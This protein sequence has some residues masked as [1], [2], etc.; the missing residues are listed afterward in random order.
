MSARVD[1]P[2]ARGLCS[3]A[4]HMKK[5]AVVPTYNERENIEQLAR[6]VLAVDTETDVLVVDDNSPDGTGA[7][8]DALAS[9]EPRV[10][11]LHR[12][13]KAGIG[14]AYKAGFTRALDLGADLV[15]QMDADFSHPPQTLPEFYRL[16]HEYDLALGSRY[17][18]GIT[19]INW[20]MGRLMLS[21]FGN[22]Y[23]QKVLGGLPIKDTTGGYKCWRR[24]VLEAIG[25]ADVRSNGYAFQ[26]EMNYRAWRLGFR[27]KE[28]PIVFVDRRVGSSKMHLSIAVEALTIV[29]RLRLQSL[30]GRLGPRSAPVAARPQST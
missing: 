7:I 16:M 11:V 1:S 9:T 27:I 3:P 15:V 25:L 10:H 23:A 14:P 13:G 2:E 30:L 26:I 6:A 20:P 29:W 4:R 24:E 18:G 28:L 8:V 21:Y 5:I 12:P 22:L 17:V 19:V